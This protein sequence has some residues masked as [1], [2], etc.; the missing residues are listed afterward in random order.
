[1][2]KKAYILLLIL[3]VGGTIVPAQDRFIAGIDYGMSYQVGLDS[4]PEALIIDLD[5]KCYTSAKIT[6]DIFTEVVP[7][8]FIITTP[9]GDTLVDTGPF[10]AGCILHFL[11][12]LV[13]YLEFTDGFLIQYTATPQDHWY[14]YLIGTAYYTHT[15]MARIIINSSEEYLLFHPIPYNGGNTVFKFYMHPNEYTGS[16]AP[17]YIYIGDITCDSSEVMEIFTS[18]GTV[19][20]DT[21]FVSGIT[22][23]PELREDIYVDTI[24][25]VNTYLLYEIHQNNFFR[26][27]TEPYNEEIEVITTAGCSYTIYI[28]VGVYSPDDVYIPN[29]FSPNG[30]GSNDFFDFYPLD[31]P[32]SRNIKIFTK[33]GALVHDSPYPWDGGAYQPGVYIFFITLQYENVYYQYKGDITLLK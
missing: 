31:L 23:D 29:A 32:D 2:I 5:N 27:I 11:D 22:L 21:I 24:V 20:C 7:D 3:V 18:N 26:Y 30:D 16:S 14:N 15:S 6:I 17:A 13:G 25:P 9:S 8:G 28:N 1:M 12:C 10:G 19:P 4:F 33:W